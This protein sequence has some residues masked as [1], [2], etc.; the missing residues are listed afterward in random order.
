MRAAGRHREGNAECSE[1]RARGYYK[2]A[3]LGSVHYH[4]DRLDVGGH[5]ARPLRC[6]E[7]ERIA[8]GIEAE[9]LTH[10]ASGLNERSLGAVGCRCGAPRTAVALDAAVGEGPADARRT[11]VVL[12]AATKRRDFETGIDQRRWRRPSNKCDRIDEGGLVAGISA[13]ECDRMRTAGRHREGN[14]ECGEARARG[15]YQVADL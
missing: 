8:A 11:R 12:I 4:P 1:A 13:R 6:L 9:R 14:A 3:D 7:R 15:Y 10:G 2:V 5:A